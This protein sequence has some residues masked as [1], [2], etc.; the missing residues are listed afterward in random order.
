M[1]PV[2]APAMRNLWPLGKRCHQTSTII[3]P[4]C[5]GSTDSVEVR[6]EEGNSRPWTGYSS[7][8]DS[9]DSAVQSRDVRAKVGL[10]V[11][12]KVTFPEHFLSFFSHLEL[13]EGWERW[14]LFCEKID[15]RRICRKKWKSASWRCVGIHRG[16]VDR[17]DEPER[18]CEGC[19]RPSSLECGGRVGATGSPRN[20]HAS[21]RKRIDKNKHSG[22][23]IK[24]T[25]SLFKFT[26][27]LWREGDSGRMPMF[28]HFPQQTI[29]PNERR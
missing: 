10:G 3:S 25:F 24:I 29:L 17:G 8:A 28:H 16:I 15:C 26:V 4:F 23:R 6:F 19:T 14:A 22:Q 7:G 9:D 5:S 11:S 1:L 2:S 27:F 13:W 21:Q 18:P 20:G 12:F